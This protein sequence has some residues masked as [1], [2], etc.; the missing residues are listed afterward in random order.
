MHLPNLLTAGPL[1]I[2]LRSLVVYL[3]LILGLRLFGKRELSQLSVIDLVFIL[4]IS[5]AV[6]NAMV[7][8]DASLTGGLLAAATLFTVNFTLKRL[9]YRHRRIDRLVQ[10]EPVMLVYHG[11][12]KQGN[13][14]KVQMSRDEME[15]AVREHGL[16]SVSQVDLA[17]LEMDGSISVLSN[18]FGKKTRRQ[19]RAHKIISKNQS[20]Q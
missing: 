7:G 18:E 3:A 11:Q 6:Q 15:E 16:S 17:V 4:L 5:N 2:M 9:M 19:R 13:L 20:T 8:P 12:I 1:N 10:G 14:D